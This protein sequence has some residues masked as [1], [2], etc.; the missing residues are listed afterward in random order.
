M[1]VL[2]TAKA[3]P[4]TSRNGFIKVGES[5]GTRMGDQ[6][7]RLLKPGGEPRL[8]ARGEARLATLMRT[9]LRE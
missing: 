3:R 5:P 8:K 9:V 7:F 4:A 2:G 1:K 6:G